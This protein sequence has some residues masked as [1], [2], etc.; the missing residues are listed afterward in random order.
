[1]ALAFLAVLAAAAAFLF[2]SETGRALIAAP[3]AY[4]GTAR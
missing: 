3:A 1:V 4:E 2:L